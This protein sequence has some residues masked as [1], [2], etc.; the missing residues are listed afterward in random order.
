MK[1]VSYFLSVV[2]MS[3]LVACCGGSSTPKELAC[4]DES[5]P[6]ISE[7]V[8]TIIVTPTE[9]QTFPEY[10]IVERNQIDLSVFPKTDDGAIILFCGKTLYGWRGY[11]KDT[12]P[13]RW[14]IDEE[15]G[16]LKVSGSGEGEAHVE[17][18][19]DLIFAHKFKN[20]ILSVDWK[21]SK[22]GNSGI[23]YLAQEIDG[24]PIYISSPES[25]I[26]DNENHLDAEMGVDGNRKSSSLYD[27]IPAK[28]QNANPFGEWNNTQIRVEKGS[29]VHY[30]NGVP[31]LNYQVWTARW[32][33]MLQASKFNQKDWALAFELLNNVGDKNR[34]GYIGLQDHGDDIWFK[35]ITIKILD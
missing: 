11:D 26:L 7:I 25:Q 6:F 30:Q 8:E 35:N 3:A 34:A 4:P 15:E 21:A 17:N 22:A 13:G 23:F 1:K 14:T 16:A 10:T 32:T 33:E 31:V 27:M 18:G 20:F 29:V 2:F 28:P 5:V 12:V 19:G 24:H 9:G